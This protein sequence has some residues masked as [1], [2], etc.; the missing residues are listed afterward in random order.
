MHHCFRSA[1]IYYS[2][3]VQKR[4]ESNESVFRNIKKWTWK[5]STYLLSVRPSSLARFSIFRENKPLWGADRSFAGRWNAPPSIDGIFQFQVLLKIFYD[6]TVIL[7]L[8]MFEK[9]R[10]FSCF[11]ASTSNRIVQLSNWLVFV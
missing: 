11:Y 3:A 6:W 1:A 10:L 2:R 7:F 5:E 9:L 4:W 8:I